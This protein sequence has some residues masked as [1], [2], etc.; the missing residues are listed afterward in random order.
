MSNVERARHTRTAE[1]S[2][3]YG[4]VRSSQSRQSGPPTDDGYGGHL[5]RGGTPSSNR[6]TDDWLREPMPTYA[7]R[8]RKVRWLTEKQLTR[9][10]V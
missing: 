6:E 5:D 9:P 8:T 4:N 10:G 1:A 2:S 7:E 3:S